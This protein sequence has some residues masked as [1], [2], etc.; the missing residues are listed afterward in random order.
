M[1]PITMHKQIENP[2]PCMQRHNHTRSNTL[3]APSD[4]PLDSCLCTHL[5]AARL[6]HSR[7]HTKQY[8]VSFTPTLHHA[9]LATAWAHDTACPNRKPRGAM[10]PDCLGHR[11]QHLQSRNLEQAIS[12]NMSSSLW[13]SPPSLLLHLESAMQP[14][15]R[16]TTYQSNREPKPSS[17]SMMS[18]D[19]TVELGRHI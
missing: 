11:P 6:H 18:F 19:R 10:P 5:S 17:L 12:I 13:L 2:N 7:L 3:P 14:R 15:S 1:R 8:V 4:P 16:S 9:L